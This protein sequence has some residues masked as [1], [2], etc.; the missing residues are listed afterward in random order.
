MNRFYCRVNPQRLED[1]LA[2]TNCMR[3]FTTNYDSNK[4]S[5]KAEISYGTTSML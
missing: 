4:Y 2:V 3:P 1:S 5:N